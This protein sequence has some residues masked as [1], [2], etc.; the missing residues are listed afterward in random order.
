MPGFCA[1]IYAEE[2][3]QTPK[4]NLTNVFWRLRASWESLFFM[5]HCLLWQH[6]IAR[7]KVNFLEV[8]YI[9]QS[10]CPSE[11]VLYWHSW[12][13]W[14]ILILSFV[15]TSYLNHHPCYTSQPMI[16]KPNTTP[17]H[18][19]PWMLLFP[20]WEVQIWHLEDVVSSEDWKKQ[21]LSDTENPCDFV[22]IMILR[23]YLLIYFSV[24][25]P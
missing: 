6:S 4:Q 23:C 12:W 22:P 7:P 1:R 24:P 20:F 17:A 10:S 15:L 3:W 19:T 11:K 5:C 16:S 9:V 18:L 21:S 8:R 14:N 2:S 13:N 25:V